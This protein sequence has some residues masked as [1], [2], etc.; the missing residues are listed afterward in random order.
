MP[1]E[2]LEKLHSMC[3]IGNAHDFPTAVHGKLRH[4]SINGTNTGQSRNGG[5]NGAAA[6]AIVADCDVTTQCMP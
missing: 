6:W 2:S 3:Q 1:K 5:S 4:A